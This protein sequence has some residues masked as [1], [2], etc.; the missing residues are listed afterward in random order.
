MKMVHDRVKVLRYAYCNFFTGGLRLGLG[1][2]YLEIYMFTEEL[3]SH[4]I[5]S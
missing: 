2:G 4:S 3:E 5:L 1:P